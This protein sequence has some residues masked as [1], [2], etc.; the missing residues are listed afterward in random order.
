MLHSKPST[1]PSPQST[2]LTTDSSISSPLLVD[3]V[4]NTLKILDVFGGK[5]VYSADEAPWQVLTH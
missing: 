1:T 2:V 4:T 3:N 5:T